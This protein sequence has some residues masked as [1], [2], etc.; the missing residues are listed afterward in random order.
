MKPVNSDSKT[1]AVQS[2][3]EVLR[4]AI[5]LRKVVNF[6]SFGCVLLSKGADLNVREIPT[7]MAEDCKSMTGARDRLCGMLLFA[8]TQG[9]KTIGEGAD[10]KPMNV[11]DFVIDALNN[12]CSVEFAQVK[13]AVYLLPAFKEAIANNVSPSLWYEVRKTM[14]EKLG[15]L[16]EKTLKLVAPSEASSARLESFNVIKAAI[17]SKLPHAKVRKVLDGEKLK[18]VDLFPKRGA[19]GKVAAAPVTLTTDNTVIKGE[20]V[21]PKL[22]HDA[23]SIR[24]SIQ[25]ARMALEYWRTQSDLAAQEAVKAGKSLVEAKAMSETAENQEDSK[26]IHDLA[27]QLARSVNPVAPVKK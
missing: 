24:D 1:V 15:S 9:I 26:V 4:D 17:D 11:K 12:D 20:S 18:H 6:D 19:K 8:E 7:L 5:A 27:I 22:T 16:D 13:Q 2:K 10:A 14:A 3:P 25:K 21:V 23:A